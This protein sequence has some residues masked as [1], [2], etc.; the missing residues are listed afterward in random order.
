M[1]P[2]RVW[3]RKKQWWLVIHQLRQKRAYR[4]KTKGA[5]PGQGSSA[6]RSAGKKRQS[7]R[8]YT[9]RKV[10]R[11]SLPRK[12]G[13][14][15]LID[16]TTRYD[17]ET[18]MARIPLPVLPTLLS[19]QSDRPG[20]SYRSVYLAVVDGRIPAERAANGRWTVSQDDLPAIAAAFGLPTTVAIAA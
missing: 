7:Q 3:G 16:R 1:L 17:Q 12:R 18:P 8:A 19:R 5:A 4:A 10:W 9:P 20:P 14:A 11:F 13:M 15:R 2:V 6:F